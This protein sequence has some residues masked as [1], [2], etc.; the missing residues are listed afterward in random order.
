MLIEFFNDMLVPGCFFA[1]V[2]RMIVI[3]AAEKHM[4]NTIGRIEYTDADTLGSSVQGFEEHLFSFLAVEVGLFEKAFFINDP[5]VQRPRIFGQ[6]KGSIRFH[7]FGQ[8]HRIDEGM[9]NRKRGSL[10][11]D[12][13]GGYVEV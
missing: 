1:F 9:G 13:N 8:V 6:T 11:I 7:Q 5:F 4:L 10:R 3:E 12:L 2:R